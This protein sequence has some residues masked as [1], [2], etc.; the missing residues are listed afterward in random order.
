MQP[1]AFVNNDWQMVRVN[2]IYLTLQ[3]FHGNSCLSS[4]SKI[5]KAEHDWI[6]TRLSEAK[7][8]EE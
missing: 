2:R 1:E 3:S 5:N 7:E 6:T 4:I 8:L